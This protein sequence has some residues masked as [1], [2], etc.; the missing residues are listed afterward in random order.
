MKLRYRLLKYF[1]IALFLSLGLFYAIKQGGP[2]TLKLYIESGIGNCKNIP[3][4]CVAPEDNFYQARIDD[5]FIASLHEYDLDQIHIHTPEGFKVVKQKIVIRYYKKKKD[6]TRGS[7]IYIVQKPE[8]FFVTIFSDIIKGSISNDYD[9]VS[10]VMNAKINSIVNLKDAFFVIMKGIFTPD[11]GDQA[12]VKIVKVKIGKMNGFISYNY[13]TLAN[14]FDCNLLED[15]GGYYK[16]YIKDK[17]KN[18][19]LDK[20][21]SMLSTMRLNDKVPT[22]KILDF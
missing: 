11:L 5:E 18:L 17:A 3:I 4:L 20:V 2:A 8:D 12:S 6:R 19:D 15:G 7:A 16:V 22:G 10:R 13:E 21:V 9:F 14:Y 1:L